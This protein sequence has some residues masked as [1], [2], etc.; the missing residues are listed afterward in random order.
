MFS[1]IVL[2]VVETLN[3][4]NIIKWDKA[5]VYRILREEQ[6]TGIM[7]YGKKQ[8][9]EIG[10]NKKIIMPRKL[11]KIIENHHQAI[12]DKELFQQVREKMSSKY[13]KRG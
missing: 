2:Y 4:D 1:L 12:I 3:N 9:K 10:T 7:I 13:L 11:W 6:Y 8:T 5:K